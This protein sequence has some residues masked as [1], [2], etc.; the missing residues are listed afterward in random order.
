MVGQPRTFFNQLKSSK[1]FV[2]VDNIDKQFVLI[3][4]KKLFRVSSQIRLHFQV[5][6][7]LEFIYSFCYLNNESYCI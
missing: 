1:M 7:S 4:M 3:F 5:T 2:E 6:W